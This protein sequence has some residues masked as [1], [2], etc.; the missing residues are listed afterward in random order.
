MFSSATPRR[1]ELKFRPDDIYAKP[2]CGDKSSTLG[3]VLKIRIKRKK[4][5]TVTPSTSTS[6]GN[7]IENLETSISCVKV[8]GVCDEIFRFESKQTNFIGSRIFS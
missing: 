4:V 1:L 5:R 6:T 2:A 3:I 7:I 8:L